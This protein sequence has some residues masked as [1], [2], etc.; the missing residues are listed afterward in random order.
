MIDTMRPSLVGPVL[1]LLLACGTALAA[2]PVSA[3][4]DLAAREAEVLRRYQDLE[5]AFLRLAD[6]LAATDPDRAAALRAAFDRGREARMG[7]RIEAIVEQLQRGQLLK[8]GTAQE[9]ALEQF[10]SLLELLEAGGDDRRADARRN[11]KQLLGR[12]AKVTS[13]QRELEAA[14]E[15]GDDAAPLSARQRE[16]ADETRRLA[17]DVEALAKADAEPARRPEAGG[18]PVD[19][20]QDAQAPESQAPE[21]QAK[22]SQAK[23]SQ[24]ADGV[25]EAGDGETARAR[26]TARRLRAAEE[27]MQAARGRLEEARRDDAR[28]EQ[29]RA[30]E[31]LETARAELE[32]ILRQMREEEVERILVQLEARIRCMLKA[33]RAV[34]GDTEKLAAAD[35]AGSPRERQLEAAR[36]G[37][38]QEKVGT[39]GAKAMALVRD[40]GSAVAIPQAL[41][42]VRDDAMQAAARLARADVGRETV[43]ILGDIVSGLEEMLAAVEK[44]HRDQAAGRPGAG[45]GGAAAGD[46]PLVDA[47]A[48]LKM[49]RTLQVRVNARTQRLSRLLDDDSTDDPGVRGVLVRLAERQR[50]IERAARDIVNGITE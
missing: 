20:Q 5:G 39:D 46:Q 32:E 11:L 29:E 36:I 35:A 16:M 34:L 15:A 37:R 43:A 21:S 40:D 1:A 27:R 8:A 24:A 10:R 26:R 6:V 23:E 14:T 3:T 42:Q 18:P 28:A 44:A 49:L 4:A 47:L 9:E 45:G 33:E 12:V 13:R 48:E 7:E 38:E 25:D 41:E 31:E 22:E 19:G 2:E 17:D 50:A 30:V